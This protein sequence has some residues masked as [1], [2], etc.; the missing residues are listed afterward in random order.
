[1]LRIQ[2]ILAA[3]AVISPS[4]S[5]AQVTEEPRQVYLRVVF[6][7]EGKLRPT[8][9]CF[10][11]I[12]RVYSRSRWWSE[13]GAEPGSSED[14]FYRVIK[15]FKAK[16]RD[17]L[18]NLSDP[19]SREPK[20][21]DAQADA[22]FQQFGALELSAIPRSIQVESLT[23][24]LLTVVFQGHA[25][26]APMVFR[27]GGNGQNWF[28]PDKSKS[29]AYS[30]A[31]DWLDA[32]QQA[33]ISDSLYCQQS[34]IAQATHRIPLGSDP[35][36]PEK[37]KSFLYVK[38][39]PANAPAVGQPDIRNSV[40]AALQT[41][42]TALSSYQGTVLLSP[43]A[44]VGAKRLK[45]WWEKAS[46]TERSNYVQSVVSQRAV[47]VFDLSPLLVL[48]SQSENGIPR[49]MY[50]VPDQNNRLMWTN[51][52]YGTTVDRIFK[53]GVLYDAA[54]ATPPFGALALKR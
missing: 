14:A 2:L 48:Y 53:D 41:V 26:S 47:F 43:I 49:V 23:V 24:F 31:R 44:N 35:A 27:K 34:A 42:K 40:D 46:A 36:V 3:S 29:L 45:D 7:A 52:S 5:R 39:V 21:F 1:M 12:E 30:L 15:A 22:F 13:A 50:F 33:E 28:L 19:S 6:N 38:G 11:A 37:D 8:S 4:V 17:G 18:R 16:D 32:M 51:S 25:T 54:R 10:N 9:G 20:V